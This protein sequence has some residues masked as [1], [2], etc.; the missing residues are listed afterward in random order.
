M[1]KT[2]KEI[3]YIMEEAQLEFWKKVVELLPEIKTGDLGFGETII[4]D[5]ACIRAIEI[6]IENSEEG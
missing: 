1:K 5:E 2:E 3:D 6:W 4:F